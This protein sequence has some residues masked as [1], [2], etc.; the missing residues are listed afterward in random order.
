[1]KLRKFAFKAVIS[2]I[3][4]LLITVCFNSLNGNNQLLKPVVAL[5]I[6]HSTP[7]LA[8]NTN[9]YQVAGLT[10]EQLRKQMARLGPLDTNFGRR[11]NGFTKWYIHWNYNYS[12]SYKGC[13]LSNIKVKTEVTTILPKWNAPRTASLAL[14]SDWNRYITALSGHE[15]GH[16]DHAV[17]AGKEILQALSSLPAYS[18]CEQLGIVA[19]A[20]GD[21]IIKKYNQQDI[22]YDQITHHGATQGAVFPTVSRE[23]STK[24]EPAFQCRPT[25]TNPA[26][27]FSVDRACNSQ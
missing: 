20:A 27:D 26:L 25:D 13:R 4:V 18:S 12:N 8:L 17:A 3:T 11:Y 19:N 6:R 5:Q 14:V 1:M 9:Y 2:A 16:K 24:K 15:S 22:S 10:V 7:N 21:R 23:L